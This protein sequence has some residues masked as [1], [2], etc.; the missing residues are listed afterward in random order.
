MDS[1]VEQGQRNAGLRWNDYFGTLA[2][3][4]GFEACKS[5]PTVYRHQ[6]RHMLMNV[7]IDD[8]LLVGS[9][10]DVEWFESEF[11]KVLKMK[12]DGPCGV[13]DNQTIMYLKRELESRNSEFYL[14]TSRKYIPKLAEMMEVVER[15]NKTLPYRPGLDTYDPK[16]V[17]EKELLNEENAKKFRSGIGI[18][19]YLAHDRIDI[20]YAVRILSSYMSRPTKNAYCGLKKL[21][22][23][24]KSTADFEVEYS[25]STNI[26]Q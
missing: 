1:T 22:C 12:K 21:A 10:E 16:A 19:L 9:M 7:H 8:I 5:I 11:N 24:L 25:G 17:D 23:Y 15:R 26:S 2:K 20:Q 3:E 6:Q 13:G 4:K 14:R 18:C